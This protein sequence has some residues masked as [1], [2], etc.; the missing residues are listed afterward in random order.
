M[1]LLFLACMVLILLHTSVKVENRIVNIQFDYN[2]IINKI[3]RV[4]EKM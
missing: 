2:K 1:K 3:K 4:V